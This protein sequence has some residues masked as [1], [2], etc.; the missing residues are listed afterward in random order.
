[1]LRIDDPYY[2]IL[3]FDVLFAKTCCFVS[4]MICFSRFKRF[5]CL[6]LGHIH[7][8]LWRK[9][10]IEIVMTVTNLSL[11]QA[12]DSWRL[13]LHAIDFLVFNIF[14][15]FNVKF[16]TK[17]LFIS[18]DTWWTLKVPKSTLLTISINTL[19]LIGWPESFD[20]D[21]HQHRL[22]GRRWWWP[23]IVDICWR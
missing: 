23:T 7:E 12:I 19:T 8:F 20:D 9:N 6:T 14:W 16:T 3:I 17:K 11:L 15:G 4:N 13:F 21:D 10:S 18:I 1:M 5:Y 2:R 22:R